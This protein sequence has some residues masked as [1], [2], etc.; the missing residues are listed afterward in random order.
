MPYT[1]A[2][3][4]YFGRRRGLRAR[5]RNGVKAAVVCGRGTVNA[6]FVLSTGI[7]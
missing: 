4:A 2:G 6:A 5:H 7:L 3:S 1:V